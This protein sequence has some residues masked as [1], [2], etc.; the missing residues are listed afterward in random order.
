MNVKVA[1]LVKPCCHSSTFSNEPV[2]IEFTQMLTVTMPWLILCF[3]SKVKVTVAI[4][5]KNCHYEKALAGGKYGPLGA[6][7]S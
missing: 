2:L 3:R 4:L 7:S 5:R 1:I 6:C